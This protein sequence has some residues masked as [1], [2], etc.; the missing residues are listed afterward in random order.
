MYIIGYSNVKALGLYNKLHVYP[1]SS[2][3]E[4]NKSLLCDCIAVLLNF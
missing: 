2:L 1:G 3:A 4:S